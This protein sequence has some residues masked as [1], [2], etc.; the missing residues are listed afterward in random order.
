MALI[1]AII[2]LV[3]TIILS[4]TYINNTYGKKETH[5]P[6]YVSE[7]ERSVKWSNEYDSYYDPQTDCYFFLNTDV[8]PEIWQYWFESISSDYG[9]YGWME[10]DYKERRWYIQTGNN[11]WEVLPSKYKND[12]N[13]WYFKE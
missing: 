13:L 10:Y 5:K 8:E 7:L 11:T 2:V 3:L 12:P 6:I 9:D 1:L 4:K